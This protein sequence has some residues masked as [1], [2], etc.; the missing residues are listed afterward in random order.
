MIVNIKNMLDICGNYW[1]WIYNIFMN[2]EDMRELME[3]VNDH[4][5]KD[6]NHE[7]VSLP[8]KNKEKSVYKGPRYN[9]VFFNSYKESKQKNSR[10]HRYARILQDSYI[11]GRLR[12]KG[13]KS[14]DITDEMIKLQ[15]LLIKTKRAIRQQKKGTD[16][17]QNIE[18]NTSNGN[19]LE[20]S[21][22]SRRRKD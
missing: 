4:I 22:R 16:N 5:F 8:I 3:R 20:F 10:V 21:L 2:F 9:V 15:K 11:K 7:S 17:G 13:I 18:H 14:E 12:S 6:V 19:I 1:K